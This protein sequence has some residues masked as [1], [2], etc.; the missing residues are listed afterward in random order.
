MHQNR[1]QYSY[2][3]YQDVLLQRW[4]SSLLWLGQK[5]KNGIPNL[6][7]CRPT[8]RT[9][10]LPGKPRQKYFKRLYAKLHSQ[11]K[12]SSKNYTF[13]TLTYDRKKWSENQAAMLLPEHLK[14]F[15]RRLRKRVKNLQYFW[16]V[17]L[18]KVGMV[19]IHLIFNQ[20]VFHKVI[21]AIWY[22]ITRSY[23]TD[24]RKIPC[25]NVA[26]YVTKYLTKQSKHSENQ[27]DYM[28][29]HISRLWNSSRGFFTRFNKAISE[30]TFLG[31]SF[32]LMRKN[33]TIFRYDPDKDMW[34]VPFDYQFPLMCYGGYIERKLSK[35]GIEYAETYER[36]VY[37]LSITQKQ[38]YDKAD[39]HF[40]WWRTK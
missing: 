3:G 14:E 40:E 36:L 38:L 15:F 34:E 37:S 17:E 24:I 31:M 21:R 1:I 27:F 16:V 12:I 13:C 22:H 23:I 32:N 26:A 7:F 35:E 19:H 2:P 10:W 4:H 30:Y 18:T 11:L 9:P 25:R 6:W 28:F 39:N 5:D 29:K 8:P 20:F 33:S